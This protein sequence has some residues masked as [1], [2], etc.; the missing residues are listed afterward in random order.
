MAQQAVVLLL[1]PIYETE[2]HP[3]SFG[4]R[5]ER[6]AYQA[7]QT[8]RSHIMEEGGRWILDVDVRKYFD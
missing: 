5:R 4:F 3:C 7:L 1:E 8:L 6:S 2:F